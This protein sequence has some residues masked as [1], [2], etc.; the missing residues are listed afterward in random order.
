MK[1]PSASEAQPSPPQRKVIKG[2]ALLLRNQRIRLQG[3]LFLGH[4]EDSRLGMESMF[5]K[6]GDSNFCYK[7]IF[8]ENRY[9]RI[10]IS[11]VYNSLKMEK[12]DSLISKQSSTKDVVVETPV[13][14]ELSEPLYSINKETEIT[15]NPEYTPVE[16]SSGAAD[17]GWDDPTSKQ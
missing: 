10:F 1:Y 9:K 12:S 2:R 17:Y 13:E 11:L 4:S 16:N 15:I 8:N 3:L 7:L 6:I 14:M 5:S